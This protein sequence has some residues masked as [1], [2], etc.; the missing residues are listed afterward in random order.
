[1]TTVAPRRP[2]RRNETGRDALWVDVPFTKAPAAK[3][4]DITLSGYAS[5]WGL[6]RDEELVAKDA[7]DKSLGDYLSKNPMVLW[8]HNMDWPIGSVTSG[9]TDDTGL[10]VTATIPDPGP[11]AADWQK[12]AYTA[13]KTGVVRTFSIG[14]YMKR[15]VKAGPDGPVFYIVEVELFETSI[16]SIPANADSLFEAAMKA[17]KGERP[18]LAAKAVTQMEQLLGFKAL[19]DPELADMDAA[20]REERYAMLSVLFERAYGVEPPALDS[21]EKVDAARKAGANPLNVARAALLLGKAFYNPEP[22][23]EDQKAGRAISAANKQKLEAALAAH[24]DIEKHMIA[25]SESMKAAAASHADAVTAIKDVAGIEADEPAGDDEDEAAVEEAA[26]EKAAGGEGKQ[27]TGDVATR[28]REEGLE[29]FGPSDPDSRVYVYVDD[30]DLDE[31]FVVYCVYGPDDESYQRVSF[32]RDGD[33]GVTLAAGSEEVQPQRGYAPKGLGRPRGLPPLPIP[34]SQ[35]S[36]EADREADEA[37][38]AS[39]GEDLMLA[40]ADFTKDLLASAIYLKSAGLEA[41]A[42]L[43]LATLA[44]ADRDRGWDAG[45]AKKRVHAWAQN[46]EGSYDASK[47]SKAYLWRDDGADAGAVGS[48]KFIV[49]DVVDGTLTYVP[50]AIFAAAGVVQGGRGGTADEVAKAIKPSIEKLYERLAKKFDDDS[51]TVPWAD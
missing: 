24:D 34:P 18:G 39:E 20:E 16:V 12:G 47:L 3:S 46:E 38:E 27:L 43:P 2:A 6:D 11:S 29:R 32:T 17:F 7:F 49:A 14:G 44:I 41:K 28:L 31:G 45:A 25:A 50:R 5:T 35:K 21:W 23:A 33:G 13:V 1:M 8:Q 37:I 9:R 51:I 40:Q 26:P 30:F 19:T 15:D 36:A 48:Y 22:S 10:Y 4:G 42:A